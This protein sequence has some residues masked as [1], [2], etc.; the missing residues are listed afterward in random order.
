MSDK[1]LLAEPRLAEFFHSYRKKLADALA[2]VDVAE[3]GRAE[4]ALAYSN[5]VLVGGNGG[6]AAISNHLCCDMSK[7]TYPNPRI[8]TVSLSSNT[9]LITA[10]ANDLG[11]EETLVRQ[12][13]YYH[14]QDPNDVVIL[15]SSSGNSPNIVKA[16]EWCKAH[17]PCVIGFTGFSGGKL[18]EL[19]DINLHVESDRYGVIEDSHQALMHC[20]AEFLKRKTIYG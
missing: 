17:G 16:A 1:H 14:P 5:T 9:P 20:L 15:I 8:R 6:S 10:I 19:A 3:L 18:S 2:S 4:R 7:G 13:E 12:L 11:Y